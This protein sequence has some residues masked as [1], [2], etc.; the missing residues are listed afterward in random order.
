[1]FW[2][3]SEETRYDCIYGYFKFVE[4]VRLN[5]VELGENYAIKYGDQ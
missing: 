4:V 3:K 1:M 5:T 2:W